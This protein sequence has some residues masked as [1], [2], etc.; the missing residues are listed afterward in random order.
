M[1]AEH[2]EQE[3]VRRCVDQLTSLQRESVSLAYYGGYTYREVAEL[4]DAPLGTVK[5]YIHRARSELR[6]LLAHLRIETKA[7]RSHDLRP[8]G[9]VASS[10]RGA[11]CA[12]AGPVDGRPS[13][14][15]SV[16]S[17]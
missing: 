3:Q 16:S 15:R 6:H 11:S 7:R 4:L 13:S 12:G 10:G 14:R 8:N 9:A 2:D 1:N 17:P 5:T